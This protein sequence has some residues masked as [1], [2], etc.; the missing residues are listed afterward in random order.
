MEHIERKSDWNYPDDESYRRD[1]WAE[2]HEQEQA[3]YSP[4]DWEEEYE[5]F[6]E[7]QDEGDDDDEDDEESH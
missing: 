2:K 4:S 1:Y 3:G 7:E 5:E 6:C